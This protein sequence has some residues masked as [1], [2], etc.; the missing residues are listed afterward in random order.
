MTLPKHSK[1]WDKLKPPLRPTSDTA[2]QMR[3]LCSDGDTLLLGVTPEFYPLFTN[4]IGTD[5][6]PK[7]VD[8]IWPGNTDNKT[9][10]VL[11]WTTME[12]H[13]EMFDTII[14]DG[15]L[16]MLG[17]LDRMRNFVTKCQTWLKPN[18]TFIHRLFER[19]D[20]LEDVFNTNNLG[21]NAF[22][23]RLVYFLAN[24]NNG[25]VPLADV[26][27]LF[28]EAFPDR[29]L[30]AAETGWSIDS[31]N[32]IDLYEGISTVTFIPNRAQWSSII[33][34][35]FVKTKGYDLAETCPLMIWRKDGI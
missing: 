16:T 19:P 26:K 30:L 12:W 18:G 24:A 2:Q 25:P 21:W 10:F 22:K 33:D 4:L 29:E 7:M 32:T 28:D 8:T 15:G 6:N 35:E 34:C 13:A 1:S 17:N 11:D 9:A 3:N 27:D 23:W 31:I 14:G 5:S 20:V